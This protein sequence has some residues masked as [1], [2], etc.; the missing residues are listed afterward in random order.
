MK[1]TLVLCLCALFIADAL[2][3]FAQQE[4]QPQS[5]GAQNAAILIGGLGA[6]NLT[7]KGLSGVF[8]DVPFVGSLLEESQKAIAGLMRKRFFDMVVD[9]IVNWIQGGG[10]PQFIQ[11]WD[12]FLASYGN[13]VTGD[14]VKEL[15]LGAVCRPFGIQLQVAIMQPPRFSRQVSCTL[16]QIVGNMVNFY[17]NFRTGGFVAYR[18]IWQPQNNFYGSAIIV[19][20]E[21]GTR[22]ADHRFPGLQER[23]G[24]NR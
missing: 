19:W 12:S 24:T 3:V 22:H 8:G 20:Y 5:N 6:T 23:H 9:Q 18:E 21:K 10:E 7:L 1:K 4:P 13:I 15:G 16:D 14:L 2:P 11:N 17:N